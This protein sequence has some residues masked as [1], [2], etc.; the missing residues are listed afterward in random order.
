MN[1]FLD[2]WFKNKSKKFYYYLAFLFLVVF[3][4]IFNSEVNY[5]RNTFQVF[6][7]DS[8]IEL[9]FI[10]KFITIVIL[11]FH[12]IVLLDLKRYY[13]KFSIHEDML[14]LLIPISISSY[15]LFNMSFN[16]LLFNL[17][18]IFMFPFLHF[19]FLRLSIASIIVFSFLFLCSYYLL[20]F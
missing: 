9:D 2:F 14:F 19:I 13:E 5:I 8:T 4:S 12:L 6:Y 3:S 20:F 7:F 18:L 11:I 16:I 1:N 10:L 15:F 17:L